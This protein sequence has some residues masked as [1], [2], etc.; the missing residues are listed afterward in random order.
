M[1]TVF[2][3]MHQTVVADDIRACLSGHELE[4]LWFTSGK[5]ELKPGEN[6]IEIF[7]P[8]RPSSH[9]RS[10]QTLADSTF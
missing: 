4:Q 8:V 7:C 2:V 6:I 5:S 9:L 1:L 10:H 3:V